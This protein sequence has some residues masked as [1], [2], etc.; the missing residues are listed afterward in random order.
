MRCLLLLLAGCGRIGF[1]DDGDDAPNE[2][3]AAAYG[4]S[5]L[6]DGPLAYFRFAE[7]AGPTAFSEVNGATGT[8]E[9]DFVFGANGAVGDTT[10]RFDTE[11][12]RIDLGDVFRFPGLAPYSI[13]IWVRPD[14]TTDTRFAI[15]RSGTGGDGYEIYFAA[16]YTIFVRQADGSENGY[17]SIDTGPKLGHW[18][19]LVGTFDGTATRLFV[20]GIERANNFGTTI[21]I[22]DEPGTFVIG[23]KD[24]PQFKKAE[25]RLDELAVYDYALDASRIQAH[26][27][28]AR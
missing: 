2:A 27:D 21:E 23:D 8:Y 22:A 19:H 12:T 10:V 17:A 25:G 9:G 14:D 5:V 18:T 6:E 13:E 15:Y 7:T 28:A 20:N 24:P 3:V 4:S 26:Y 16:G 1:S 11:T